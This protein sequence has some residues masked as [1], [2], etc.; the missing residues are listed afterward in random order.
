M[1]LTTQQV[2]TAITE[3]DDFYWGELE[4]EAEHGDGFTLTIDDKEYPVKFEEGYT[5]GEGDWNTETYVIFTLNDQ[6]FKKTGYYQSH[7]GDDW[8]GP[9]IEVHSV[10]RP[11]K[12]WEKV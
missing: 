9:L 10:V 12:V 6:S 2:E 1:K 8:D 5:G 3:D 7:Y 4:W 11:T